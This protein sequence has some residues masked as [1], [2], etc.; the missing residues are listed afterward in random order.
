VAPGEISYHGI[1]YGIIVTLGRDDR[2]S[3]RLIDL[4]SDVTPSPTVTDI[5]QRSAP[6]GHRWRTALVATGILTLAAI[7]WFALGRGDAGEHTFQTA[8]VVRGDVI[9]AVTATGVLHPVTQV[10]VGSE[11]SGVIKTVAVDYNDRVKRGQILANLDTDQLAAHVAEA[12]ASLGS[13]EAGRRQ[14]QATVHETE[15]A[16]QRCETLAKTQMCSL[17][18]LD[19]L[20]AS[21]LRAQAAEAAGVAAVSLAQANLESAKTALGKAAIVAPID[22]IVLSRYIEPGQ[23]VA[24]TFQTP[25]L[26]TLAEDLRQMQVKADIDEADIG[27]VRQGQTGSFTVDAYPGRHFPAEVSAVRFAPKTVEGVVTYEAVLAVD[28]EALLLRPGMTA[29][30]DIVTDTLHDVLLI[31]NAALRFKPPE[32]LIGA[33][34]PV[35]ANPAVRTVWILPDEDEPPKPIKVT[36][37]ATDDHNSEL[38]DGALVEGAQVVIDVREP[39]PRGGNGPP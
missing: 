7:L 26:F 2:S 32:D 29:N 20:E 17:Q 27:R 5:L 24:A 4:S 36:I 33:P 13:A 1:A 12:K 39:D 18:D 8:S 15:V 34:V 25:V 16:F 11:V 23:T 6:T 38:R 30:V 14:A 21:Y 28:N 31:P 9:A 3:K 35:E 37:G 10:D 19:Q 22:G